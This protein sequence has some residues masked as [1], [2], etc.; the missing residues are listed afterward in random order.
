M[1]DYPIPGYPVVNYTATDGIM[2]LLR[3][4]QNYPALGTGQQVLATQARNLLGTIPQVF[5]EYQTKYQFNLFGDYPFKKDI[6]PSAVF[7]GVYGILLILHLLIFILNMS[8]GHYFWITLTYIFYCACKIVGFA[9]RI[10]WQRDLSITAIGL[11]SEVLLIIPTIILVSFNLILAQ[12]IFTWRHPVGGS[13]KLFWGIMFG[14]Y[15]FVLGIVAMTIMASFVP[16][17]HMLSQA[18]Y[19]K[20]IKVQQAAAILVVLYPFT[21]VSLIGLSYFFKPTRKDENLYTYQPYWIESF[22]PFYFV[23]KNASKEAEETFMKR[24][25]NHRHAVRV[26]AATHHHYN[27]VQGLTNERGDLTHN[28]SLIIVSISTFVLFVGSLCRCI[29]VFQANYQKDS[30]AI[31]SPIAMYI[32]WGAAEA[33]VVLMYAVGR[34]DLRFYRPDRLPKKVR[35]IITAEQSIEQ[36]EEELSDEEFDDDVRTSDLSELS[37]NNYKLPS[38]E[39]QFRRE[40]EKEDNQSEFHF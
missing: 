14:F 16:Y 25:H 26:I 17:L 39:D 4:Q 2:E 34:V 8:R 32:I 19:E 3:Y 11:T 5:V 28:M 33:L 40:H 38:Y 10:V 9:C 6:V 24:N 35:A 23:K 18:N 12:R 1:V 22:H 30:S 37:F 13:R 31:C 20:Y 36:S 15:G 7:V 27:M 29:V 21:A